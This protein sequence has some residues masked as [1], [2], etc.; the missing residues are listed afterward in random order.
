MIPVGLKQSVRRD[1]P[2][3]HITV[4]MYIHAAFS[5]LQDVFKPVSSPF[6]RPYPEIRDIQLVHIHGYAGCSPFPR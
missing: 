1:R 3:Y 6:E 4:G 5:V 2:H